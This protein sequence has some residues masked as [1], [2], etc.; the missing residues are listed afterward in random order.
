MRQQPESIK[1]EIRRH[2]RQAAR[3]AYGA[4]PHALGW[5]VVFSLI[6]LPVEDWLIAGGAL[7][8]SYLFIE[9]LHVVCL[10]KLFSILLS[11]LVSA[12]RN[13]PDPNH[14]ALAQLQQKGTSKRG[15]NKALII[16]VPVRLSSYGASIV[17]CSIILASLDF[18]HLPVFLTFVGVVMW[19]IGALALTGIF[20]ILPLSDSDSGE[21][22]RRRTGDDLSS[23]GNSLST[24]RI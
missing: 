8:A 2:S 19:V 22:R 17:V 9:V 7:Y 13:L 4:F 11:R 21:S 23:L 6:S 15:G 1:T 16:S 20:A 18:V 5:L 14:P 24:P 12:I 10:A 3:S